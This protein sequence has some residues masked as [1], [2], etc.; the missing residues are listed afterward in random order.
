MRIKISATFFG[1]CEICGREE[2]VFKVGDE[3]TKK[4]LT[5]CEDCVKKFKDKKVGDMV[6]EFGK[7][8]EKSFDKG[9]E[10]S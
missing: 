4:T 3:D 7:K 8:D 10:I 5:L 2:K 1:K 6:E 9:F